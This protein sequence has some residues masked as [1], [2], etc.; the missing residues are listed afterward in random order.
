VFLAGLELKAPTCVEG[1]TLPLNR[2]QHI[3]LERWRYWIVPIAAMLIVAFVLFLF[4]AGG[5]LVSA[6]YL[7]F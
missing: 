5:R 2:V 3:L 4:S 1:D 7:M 6:I